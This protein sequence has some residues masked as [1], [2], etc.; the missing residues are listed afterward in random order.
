[1]PIPDDDA[2]R[3]LGISLVD[4][5]VAPEA[6]AE[7]LRVARR[8]RESH[9]R[10]I[11]LVP[12]SARLEIPMIAVQLAA[13]MADVCDGPIAFVDANARWPALASVATGGKGAPGGLVRVDLREGVVALS[14]RSS[15]ED[16]IDPAWLEETLDLYAGQFAHLLVDLTGFAALGEHARAFGV[17][18]G[19][20]ILARSGVTKE[21]E[22][23]ACHRDVPQSRDMGVLLA[24]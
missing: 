2:L 19:V 15:P 13:V 21:H 17:V 14:R 3:K 20:L 23:L 12:A 11:G 22:L 18:D 24:G 10:S 7:L 16:R 6:F 5:S 9:R 1:M 8:I 4:P